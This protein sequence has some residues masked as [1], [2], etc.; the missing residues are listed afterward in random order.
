M[1]STMSS[2]SRE[3]KEPKE[4]HSKSTAVTIILS[5]TSSKGGKF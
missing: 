5:T 4:W 1:P 2:R 3:K